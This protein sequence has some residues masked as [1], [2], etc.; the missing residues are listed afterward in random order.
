MDVNIKDEVR[1]LQDVHPEPKWQ[2]GA[3]EQRVRGCAG[4][5]QGAERAGPHL[6]VFQMWMVSSSRMSCFSACSSKKSKKYLTAGGTAFPGASTLWKKLSTNCCSVPCGGE[7]LG[8]TPW[9][10]GTRVW[11]CVPVR[12]RHHLD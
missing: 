6:L 10:T 3:D 7:R 11:G 4:R 2:T 1:V 8:V 9:D 5:W 12:E